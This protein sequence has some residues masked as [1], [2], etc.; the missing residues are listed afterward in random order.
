MHITM[1]L[2][3]M[4]AAT[5]SASSSAVTMTTVLSAGIGG[6]LIAVLLVSLLASRELIAASSLRSKRFLSILDA[7]VVPLVLLFAATVVFRVIEMVQ[8]LN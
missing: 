4:V 2:I 6:L 3:M 5:A 7:A 8:S 1:S